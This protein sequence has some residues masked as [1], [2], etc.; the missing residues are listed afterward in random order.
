MI[1]ALGE[2][3]SQTGIRSQTLENR[4]RTLDIEAVIIAPHHVDVVR[5]RINN[6]KLGIACQGK[7]SIIVQ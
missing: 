7:C 1:T 6:R 5:V 4:F 2:I 3:N